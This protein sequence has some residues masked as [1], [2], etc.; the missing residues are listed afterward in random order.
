MVL[1]SNAIALSPRAWFSRASS[2]AL[3]FAMSPCSFGRP[4]DTT[5]QAD[6]VFN[7]LMLDGRTQSGR[8]VSLGPG[9]ITL[10]SAEGAKHEL[11][12]NQVFKLTREVSGSVAAIDRSMIILPEGD[13]L[14]RVTIGTASETALDVQS[15]TL[16]K[17][18][19]PLD[20]LLGW[21]MVVPAETDALDALV[22]SRSSRA[23]QG[24]SRVALER[25]PALG[26]ISG[27]GRAQDQDP[28]ERQAA[29]SR[30]NGDRGGRVRPGPCQLCVGPSRGSW[31]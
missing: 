1:Q 12:L 9:A 5:A 3:A 29:G 26:R 19:V 21:I 22:G 24:G 13:C 8:L 16:G 15:D 14:M 31:K 7:A 28:G 30:T 18:A 10:A 11:P 20:C 17:L 4:A 6:P 27:M 23:A 25:R 2:W